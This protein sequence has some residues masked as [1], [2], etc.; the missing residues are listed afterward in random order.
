MDDKK[1]KLSDVGER[2]P[3]SDIITGAGSPSP[4]IDARSFHKKRARRKKERLAALGGKSVAG[5]RK[6]A[7]KEMRA[8][9][10]TKKDKRK[11]TSPMKRPKLRMRPIA[12]KRPKPTSRKMPVVELKPKI[13]PN[14]RPGPRPISATPQ[15]CPSAPGKDC[16]PSVPDEAAPHSSCLVIDLTV[17]WKKAFAFFA[18]TTRYK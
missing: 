15:N 10:R 6:K 3:A 5:S 12:K 18:I 14:P 16:P 1:G 13:K 8:K 2:E 7:R 11:S 17:V 9:R 4:R